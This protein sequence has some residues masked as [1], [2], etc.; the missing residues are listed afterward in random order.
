MRRSPATNHCHGCSLPHGC[1][2]RASVLLQS[3]TCSLPM[4]E[5]RK[6]VVPLHASARS[7][8]LLLYGFF[9]LRGALLCLHPGQL[10]LLYSSM[11]DGFTVTASHFNRLCPYS[12]VTWTKHCSDETICC[13]V[14]QHLACLNLLASFSVLDIMP[15][16][17]TV[18]MC[19]TLTCLVP[20]VPYLA[21]RQGRIWI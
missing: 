5:R 16:R 12:A 6:G 13:R 20:S 9:F 15:S 18:N 7:R 11:V 1:N 8:W 21:S 3:Y 17:L 4:P 2:F 14:P 10:L 19:G